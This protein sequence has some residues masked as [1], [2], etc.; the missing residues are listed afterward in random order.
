VQRQTH[1]HIPSE[2]EFAGLLIT[3]SLLKTTSSQKQ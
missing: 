3:Q 2:L 1:G